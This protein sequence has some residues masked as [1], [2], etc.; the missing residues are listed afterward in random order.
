MNNIKCNVYC[1][2]LLLHDSESFLILLN[3]FYLKKKNEDSAQIAFPT[4]A[5][6]ISLCLISLISSRNYSAGL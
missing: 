2:L 4:I 3:G 5:P 1:K 6:T